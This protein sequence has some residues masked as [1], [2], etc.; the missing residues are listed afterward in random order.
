MEK[1]QNNLSKF[2]QMFHINDNRL[3]TGPQAKF[4]LLVLSN[5]YIFGSYFES[6]NWLLLMKHLK[7]GIINLI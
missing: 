2:N 6:Y 3:G 4:A 5:L 1:L 7:Q